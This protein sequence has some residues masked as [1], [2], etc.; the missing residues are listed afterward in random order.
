MDRTPSPV[1]QKGVK[2]DPWGT[3]NMMPELALYSSPSVQSLESAMHSL[4][5][6]S[7]EL[8]RFRVVA[9]VLAANSTPRP[10]APCPECVSCKSELREMR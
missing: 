4:Q 10:P 6:L 9:G 2:P 7:P 5:A 8:E 1:K 3:P